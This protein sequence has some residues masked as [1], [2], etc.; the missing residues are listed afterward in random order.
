MAD[1]R[2]PAESYLTNRMVTDRCMRFW[3]HNQWKGLY[4][5]SLQEPRARAWTLQ[6]IGATP[7]LNL[8][9]VKVRELYEKLKAAAPPSAPGSAAP[10]PA[11]VPTSAASA[12]SSPAA[13]EVS[14]EVVTADVVSADVVGQTPVADVAVAPQSAGSDVDMASLELPQSKYTDPDSVS[15]EFTAE[16]RRGPVPAP[17]PPEYVAARD[18]GDF[19]TAAT[20]LQALARAT[21]PGVSIPMTPTEF[22]EL[23][24]ELARLGVFPLIV[25]LCS[26]LPTHITAAAMSDMGQKLKLGT[27]LHEPVL[28]FDQ[29]TREVEEGDEKAQRALENILVASVRSALHD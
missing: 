12:P 26:R 24:G 5:F 19:F 13:Q 4:E 2:D 9:D 7:N 14:A 10:P 3:R 17:L 11:P 8:L 27:L 20:V 16:T 29:A 6:K 23:L 28:W 1:T 22:R 25:D 15:I 21:P 18:K